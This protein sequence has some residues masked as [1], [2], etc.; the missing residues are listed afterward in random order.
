[1]ADRVKQ[2]Q[3]AYA[4]RDQAYQRASEIVESLSSLASTIRNWQQIRIDGVGFCDEIT[5]NNNLHHIS[6]N[7]WPT[8]ESFKD[9]VS[10][11]HEATRN[12]QNIWRN[13]KDAERTG[14]NPPD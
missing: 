13:M 1:M 8:F 2:Y 10:T 3:D 5:V 14:L 4:S 9:A 7:D 12:A 11:Y 6:S